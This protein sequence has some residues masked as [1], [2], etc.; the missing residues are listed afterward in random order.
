MTDLHRLTATQAA[1]KLAA[2]EITAEALVDD[3][4]ARIAEHDAQVRAWTHVDAHGARARA[5]A[6]DRGGSAGPLHGLPIAV[7][8]L[9][10]TVDMP[11]SYG[12]P[13]YAGH[14]P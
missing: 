5:R 3:C 4:L 12:S 1:R 6:L 13:I 8:D 10:D 2:R 14:R 11:T 9:F 7:K